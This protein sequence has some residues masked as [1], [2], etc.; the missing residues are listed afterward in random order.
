MSYVRSWETEEHRIFR[1]AAE[2][3]F[4]REL[5]PE[6]G[7]WIAQG[8]VDRDAWRKTGQAGLLLTDIPQ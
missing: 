3:F 7:R 4:E 8:I 6:L 1:E 5:A 2:R